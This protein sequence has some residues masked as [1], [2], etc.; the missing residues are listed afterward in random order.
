MKTN[1]YVDLYRSFLQRKGYTKQTQESYERQVKAFCAFLKQ[2]YPRIS[3]PT[4]VNKLIITDYHDYLCE[5]RTPGDKPLANKS[6]CLMLIALKSFFSFLV[7]EDFM[8]GDPTKALILPKQER[9]L[10][11][12]ILTEPEVM[13]ILKSCNRTTPFGLRDRA[14]LELLY[15]TGIRT[16]ELCNLKVMDVDLKDQTVFID[17]GKGNISRL[18]PIGQYASLYIEKYVQNGRRFFLKTKLHDPGCLFLTQFGNP[19]ERRSINEWVMRPIQQKLRLKKHLTVYSLRHA[20]ATHL[21]RHDVD[22]SYIAKL[23]GHRSLNTTQQYLKIEIGD[24]KR[25]HSLYHPRER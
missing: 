10:V 20:V 21:L 24:L 2:Y 18:V 6:I 25:I 1:E 15:A 14:I 8:A 23:L 4:A 11:R 22:V 16:T 9:R 13:K 19:F 7:A 17:R 3:T 5:R 12:D